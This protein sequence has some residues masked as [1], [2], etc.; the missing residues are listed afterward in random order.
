MAAKRWPPRAETMRGVDSTQKTS[1]PTL[2]HARTQSMARSALAEYS[3]RLVLTTE[4]SEQ[5]GLAKPT[6]HVCAERR[7]AELD[8]I[9]SSNEPSHTAPGNAAENMLRAALSL[10]K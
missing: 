10:S 6:R 7:N 9:D 2:A 3:L 1:C 8:A 4:M 5:G